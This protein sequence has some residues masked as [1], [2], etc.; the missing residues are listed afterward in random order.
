MR[1]V[2]DSSALAKRYV[3][4]PGTDRVL[5]LCAA[6]EEVILSIL[7]VPE[8]V[9]ALNRLRRENRLTS[10]NYTAVKD[11]LAPDVEQ[12]TLVSIT[13]S[14]LART[15][16]ILEKYPLRALDSVHLATALDAACDVFVSADRNQCQAARDLGL[17][18]EAL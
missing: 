9:S 11:D 14:I 6:A 15:I 10:K 3:V 17:T 5:E 2:F 16:E 12:A 18:V 8:I 13:P 4:E 7:C 1:A